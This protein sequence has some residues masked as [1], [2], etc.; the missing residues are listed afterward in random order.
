MKNLDLIRSGVH[1]FSGEFPTDVTDPE[2]AEDAV[3]VT[4]PLWFSPEAVVAWRYLDGAAFLYV[5]K[6]CLVVTDESLELS[7]PRWRCCC[8]EELE[9]ELEETYRFLVEDGQI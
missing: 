8:W 2:A 9:A 3:E 7:E 6:N 5:Y 1:Y 4:I